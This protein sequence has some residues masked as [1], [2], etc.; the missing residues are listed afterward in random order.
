[1]AKKREVSVARERLSPERVL[2]AAL[3]LADEGGVEALSMRKLGQVLGVEAMSLYKHL[4]NKD[5][6]LDGVLDL[7]VAEID[8]PVP[9]Q[10]WKE[11]MRRRARSAREVFIRHPW[12][13]ALMESRT[14]PGLASLRYY[15]AVI[16]CLRRAGF[17][18]VMAAHAF[19]VLDSFI[20]GFALQEQKMSFEGAAELGDVAVDLQAQMQSAGHDLP[21]LGELIVEHALKPG[22]AFAN[23][24][25]FGL[26]LILDGLER[27]RDAEGQAA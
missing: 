18:I 19:A 2:R 4:P 1:M 26:E 27:A 16:G 12:A 14:Q 17:S 13:M 20:Y 11:A 23:E 8:L 3:A 15:D 22:Y 21:Y 10:D 25:E 6:I 9:G 24:F 7:V 5:A